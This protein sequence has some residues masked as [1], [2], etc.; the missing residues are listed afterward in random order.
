MF[1]NLISELTE[2]D[3]IKLESVEN[4]L[5]EF[6]DKLISEKDLEKCTKKFLHTGVC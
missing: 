2:N 5:N 4:E 1:I 3:Y 6:A